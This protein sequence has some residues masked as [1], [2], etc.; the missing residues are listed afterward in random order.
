MGALEKKKDM[1]LPEDPEPKNLETGL[2]ELEEILETL[3]GDDLPLEE[4]FRLY[5]SGIKKVRECQ[6]TMED[7]EKRMQILKEDGSLEEWDDI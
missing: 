6:K 1:G 4:A 3:S 7:V 2:S 5:E